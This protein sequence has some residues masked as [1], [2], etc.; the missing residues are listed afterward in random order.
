MPQQDFMTGVI[1]KNDYSQEAGY[2][3]NQ[4]LS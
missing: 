3:K 2:D 4:F 1:S